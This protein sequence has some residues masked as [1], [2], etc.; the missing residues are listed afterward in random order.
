MEGY[1]ESHNRG[2]NVCKLAEIHALCWLNP[3][4]W[5]TSYRGLNVYFCECEIIFLK[6]NFYC[7]IISFS[8]ALCHIQGWL[9][10]IRSATYVGQHYINCARG[11]CS[12]GRQIILQISKVQ[13]RIIS[14]VNHSKWFILTVECSIKVWQHTSSLS[15]CSLLKRFSG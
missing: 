15:F 7:L 9:S 2:K 4:H 14:R 10:G 5:S 8:R 3:F 1:Y 13:S 6:Y 12:F 11:P